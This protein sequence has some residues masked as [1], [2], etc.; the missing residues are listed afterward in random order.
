MNLP[1][2]IM[3]SI[4]GVLAVIALSL[5]VFGYG[6]PGYGM[7]QNYVGVKTAS[8]SHP[9]AVLGEIKAEDSGYG[10]Q[11]YAQGTL[12]NNTNKKYFYLQVSAD[13]I[14]PQGE[15]VGTCVQNFMNVQAHKTY[16][17]NALCSSSQIDDSQDVAKTINTVIKGY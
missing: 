11:P 2:K 7:M 3:A 14:S 6:I 12:T 8:N 13:A 1:M 10:L 5:T 16:H 9:S 4:I 15:H 17:V